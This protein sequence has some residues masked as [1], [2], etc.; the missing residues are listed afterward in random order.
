MR[1]DAALALLHLLL[2]ASARAFQAGAVCAGA[3]YSAPARSLLRGKHLV[4][5]DSPWFPFAIKDASKAHGWDGLDVDLISAVA[6]KL[7]FTFEI[8]EMTPTPGETWTRMLFD[9]VGRADMMLSYWARTTERLD[10]VAMLNGHVDM[11]NTL[12]G[13]MSTPDSNDLSSW[14]ALFSFLRPFSLSL[15]GCLFGMVLLSG[16]VDFVLE[17]G[18]PTAAGLFSSLYE[19]FAGTLW[20]GFEYP[21]SRP[22]HLPDHAGIPP[23]RRHLRLHGQPRGGDD[24]LDAPRPLH[25]QHRGG[26]GRQHAHLLV[27]K[28]HARGD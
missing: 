28:P 4:L 6:A 11:S 22:C 23:A 20:G 21:R 7:G 5:K 18:S 24:G 1:L 13:R 12:I 27:P 10:R 16:V 3:N 19:Y 8:L 17:R 9:E 2:P 14:I 26:A 15:W 25:Q